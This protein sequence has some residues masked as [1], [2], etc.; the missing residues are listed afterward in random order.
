MIILTY[1]ILKLQ[2][3]YS[4]FLEFFKNFLSVLMNWALSMLSITALS[5]L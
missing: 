3:I 1:F 5:G 4:F 2:I